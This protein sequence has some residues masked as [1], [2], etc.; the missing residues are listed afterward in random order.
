M[1]CN[2]VLFSD[3]KI[4]L[5]V[6]AMETEKSGL[7][8][9]KTGNLSLIN[10]EEGYVIIT[11]S[12]MAKEK[13]DTQDLIVLDLDGNIIK[14]P[15][16]NKPS[17]ETEMHLECYRKRPDIGAVVHTHSAFASAFAVNGEEI[18]P[19]LTEASWYGNKT[20]LVPYAEPGSMELARN[21]GEVLDETADVLLL[22]KHGV[23]AVGSDLENA[24][25]KAKYVEE[26]A[27]V[28]CFSKLMKQS[29]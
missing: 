26:V 25:I 28:A 3:L 1:I 8:R 13:L 22:E 2:N 6:A 9:H 18:P 14:N 7:C 29:V 5:M 24:L 4:S 23:I 21:A 20:K 15:K 10:R 27:K 17:I 12:G 19:V 11:P 16:D